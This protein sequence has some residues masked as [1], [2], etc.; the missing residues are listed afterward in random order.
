MDAAPATSMFVAT[1]ATGT[2][3]FHLPAFLSDRGSSPGVAAGAI[4]GFAF[5]GAISAGLWGFLSERVAERAL[6]IVAM[7]V[8]AVT[9]VIIAQVRVETL[10][11]PLAGLLGSVSRGESALFN[12]M[13]AR[14]YGRRAYGR[15]MGM[16]Q[17][18]MIV[19]LG[20]G[21]LLASLVFDV[22]G[23]YDL[24]LAAAVILYGSG[25]V[26]ISQARPPAV[27]I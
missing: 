17:P 15:I 6:A 11:I 7:G 20:M 5:C 18:F 26:L 21:P 9:V 23:S 22:A 2:L 14:Y 27:A 3:A 24:V 16:L 8:A 4:S 19:A 13:V 12:M 10:A 25:A 1:L